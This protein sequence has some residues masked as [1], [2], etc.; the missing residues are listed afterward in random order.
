MVA[1]QFA[2]TQ[3]GGTAAAVLPPLLPAHQSGGTTAPVLPPAILSSFAPGVAVT[4]APAKQAVVAPSA[5][6][7]QTGRS[8]FHFKLIEIICL[9]YDLIAAIDDSYA[10]SESYADDFDMRFVCFHIYSLLFLS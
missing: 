1:T 2:F 3:S 5:K 10:Y 7:A 9:V 8:P 4:A 6:P